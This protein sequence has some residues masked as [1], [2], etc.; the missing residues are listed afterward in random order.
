[1]RDEV[2]R[3]EAGGSSDEMYLMDLSARCAEV[4]S[5]YRIALLRN[6]IPLVNVRTS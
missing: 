2:D 4:S 5:A 1:M 3:F 6:A